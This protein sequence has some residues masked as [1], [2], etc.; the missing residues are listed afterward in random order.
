M[1]ELRMR[2]IRVFHVGPHMD[3]RGGI[4]AV[5]SQINR[6]K[7]VFQSRG[8]ELDFFSTT[9][10][11]I[12]SKAKKLLVFLRSI[13]RFAIQR[14][15]STINIVHIHAALR[16]SLARKCIFAT[17]CNVKGIPY[18]WHIHNG[19]FVDRFNNYVF[20][21]RCLV[22]Y[23]IR[24]A[25]RTIVISKMMREQLLKSKI[26]SEEKC[27]LVFNGIE[28][29]LKVLKK[30]A[31]ASGFPIQITFM[32]LISEAKGIFTLISAI[33]SMP[34]GLPSYRVQIA[35]RGNES[36][37]NLAIR[38]FDVADRVKYIGWVS[39]SDKDS[40]L[41]ETD[42][43]V[44]PSRS[45]GFS[46]ALLEAMAYGHA[47]VSTTIPGVVDAVRNDVEGILV[48]P[49]DLSALKEALSRL[50]RHKCERTR[51]GEAARNRFLEEFTIDRMS[52]ELCAIYKSI[53]SV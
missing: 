27:I 16:G 32:G 50:I 53:A 14:K 3:D 22:K 29:P 46:V 7:A 44:L 38:S 41:R 10:P 35:G 17:I 8:Y 31:R 39:G 40:I 34:A 47:I 51:L 23:I 21:K 24:R 33:S 5:L 43:F 42:I 28:S 45:E 9:E 52:V 26:I 25:S 1:M 49:D 20:V 2:N 12:V 18:V 11:A 48:N 13:V 15:R 37:L 6:Q 4:A 19:A 30:N 36:E